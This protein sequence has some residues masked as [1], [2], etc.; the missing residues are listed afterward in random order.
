MEIR[1]EKVDKK[2]LYCDI[3]KVKKVYLLFKNSKEG[4]KK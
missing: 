1:S 3:E 4:K 2:E